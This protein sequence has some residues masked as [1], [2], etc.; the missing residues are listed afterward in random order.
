MF[1]EKFGSFVVK[2]PLSK[3]MKGFLAKQDDI[4]LV[5]KD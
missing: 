2:S 3:T 5:E 1:W 4:V